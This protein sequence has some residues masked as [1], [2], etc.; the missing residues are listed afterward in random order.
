MSV[1]IEQL[2]SSWTNFRGI[3]YW[4]LLLTF[5]EKIEVGL[6]PDIING[7]STLIRTQIDEY[8]FLTWYHACHGSEFATDFLDTVFTVVITVTDVLMITNATMV[9][10]VT[11]LTRTRIL[12]RSSRCCYEGVI[13]IS[14]V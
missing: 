5:V 10:M 3:L 1:R 7:Y 11:V 13:G 14:N 12:F 2:V 8:F 4:F 9:P 6:I